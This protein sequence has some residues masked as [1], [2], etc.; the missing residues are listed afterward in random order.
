MW[1]YKRS[2]DC[3]NEYGGDD[4]LIAIYSPYTS[5][6][7]EKQCGVDIEWDDYYFVKLY[8]ELCGYE[9]TL[10]NENNRILGIFINKKKRR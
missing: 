1:G 8:A 9:A 6:G 2:I 4:D 5:D 10:Y 7:R 3:K